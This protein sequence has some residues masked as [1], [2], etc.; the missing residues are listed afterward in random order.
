[1]FEPERSNETESRTQCVFTLAEMRAAALTAVADLMGG[2]PVSIVEEAPSLA[3]NSQ[4]EPQR[5]A[6]RID[7]QFDP[8]TKQTLRLEE[9]YTRELR[10][11]PIYFCGSIWIKGPLLGGS[12]ALRSLEGIRPFLEARLLTPER[13]RQL[14]AEAERKR[15]FVEARGVVGA[16]L[17]ALDL[18]GRAA[19]L[20]DGLAR[21]T[22]V[23]VVLPSRPDVPLMHALPPAD[24]DALLVEHCISA[25][26]RLLVARAH[27][28]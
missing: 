7:I 27:S 17:A 2:A 21:E 19:A 25:L 24:L 18:P 8:E 9:P 12:T 3:V 4:Y 6:M 10:I 14:A 20:I 22:A 15:L 28:A 23:G 26:R 13:R 5:M 16:H 11:G 1:M